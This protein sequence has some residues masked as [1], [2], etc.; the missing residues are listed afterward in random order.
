MK[1]ISAAIAAFAL[2]AL[3]LAGCSQGT[4]E[5]SAPA[6]QG[7]QEGR[8]SVVTTI[9]PEYDWTMQVLGGEAEGA[10]VTLLLDGG[11]DLHSYQPTAADIAAISECDVFVYVGGESDEWVEDVLAQAAN[12][13]MAV[14]CLMD[15]LGDAVVEEEVVEGMAAKDEEEGGEEELDEH[16]WLSPRNAQ[17][18][19][20]AIA[21]AL[22]QADPEHAATYA[23]N[24]EEYRS[25]LA[26]L[27]ADYEAAVAAGAR[28]TVL[29][30]DRFPFRYLTDDYGLDYYAA[31][32]GCSAETE[33]SF[34]TVLFLAGK[35]DELGL[36]AIL[37][38]ESSDGK[39]A[40]TVRENTQAK[41][42][43]ILVM[44]SMQSTTAADVEA[45]VTYLSIMRDNLDVLA[46][47]L[48]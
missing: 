41:D 37:T 42:Q 14:V 24:A 21:D 44:D 12:D 5:G 33:A 22:S 46:Q 17:V 45:G 19:V 3:C 30:A 1:R 40:R 36:P 35:V 15:A 25:E 13:D 48:A 47:A 28:S 11:T 38:I 6:D 34:E 32:V 27:D 2:A 23:A 31:F 29:F 7:R 9:F 16:V 10:D 43:Q 4:R 26:Q 20:G 18:L 39:I 8:L